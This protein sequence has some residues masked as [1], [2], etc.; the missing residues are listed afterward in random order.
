MYILD[1]NVALS[2]KDVTL[3]ALELIDASSKFNIPYVNV[4]VNNLLFSEYNYNIKLCS[5]TISMI[6]PSI[7]EYGT[8][9]KFTLLNSTLY[10]KC[11]YNADGKAYRSCEIKNNQWKQPSFKLC[12]HKVYQEISKKVKIY[13]F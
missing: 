3:K 6:C 8:Y 1:G 11:P 12:I 7:N 13:I 10:T 2:I 5:S 4:N 9:W